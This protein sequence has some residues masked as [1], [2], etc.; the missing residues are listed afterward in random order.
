MW[1]GI[2]KV[3]GRDFPIR[4]CVFHWAQAVWRHVG[5]LGLRPAYMKSG[6]IQRLLLLFY[7]LSWIHQII[8]Y[9]LYLIFLSRH[10][11]I[12]TGIS[13]II[14]SYFWFNIIIFWFYCRLIRKILALP[15]LPQEHIGPA[16]ANLKEQ[17][18]ADEGMQQLCEYVES[19]W[20]NSKKW[21]VSEWSVYGQATRTNND[22]EGWHN[23][24]N[25]R[26]RGANLNMYLLIGLLH[27]EAGLVK[28]QLSLASTGR[29]R[30]NQKK[31]YQKVNGKIDTLW[32]EYARGNISGSQLL[33]SISHI[34]RP[35]AN[36]EKQSEFERSLIARVWW[37]GI[38][39]I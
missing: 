3:L 17:A 6:K 14:T 29:L 10:S 5:E 11:N 31:K 38:A 20:M 28:V 18:S 21:K 1:S 9:E 23:R 30:K 7:F 2:R 32:E 15:F 25:T 4:G 36:W 35:P 13:H 8:L 34:Y 12:N 33:R 27:K 37:H 26:A 16:F 39:A 22:C 19:N 24:I